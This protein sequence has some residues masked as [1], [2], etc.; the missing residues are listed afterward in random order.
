MCVNLL[1]FSSILYDKTMNTCPFLGIFACTVSLFFTLSAPPVSYILLTHLKCFQLDDCS[2][3]S[4]A[5]I[6]QR[7]QTRIRFIEMFIEKIGME[8][9]FYFI[10][11]LKKRN[12]IWCRYFV[13]CFVSF[14][15]IDSLS[16]VRN[17]MANFD[18]IALV[19]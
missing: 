15:F 12:H 2:F 4:S 19:L 13:R 5:I 11:Y 10:L 17:V 8:C 3:N 7:M 1:F 6:N 18:S 14:L 16:H 9:I